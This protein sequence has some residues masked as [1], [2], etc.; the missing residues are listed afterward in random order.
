MRIV[1]VRL[2]ALGDIVHTWPLADA[3]RAASPEAHLTWVVEEPLAPLV[4]ATRR[5]TRS[6]PSPPRAGARNRSPN[7]TRAEIAILKTPIRGAPSGSRHRCP[8]HP[9]IGACHAVDGRRP[10][11]RSG[12]ALAP[13]AH[14]RPR[15]S[16]RLSPGAAT[17]GTWSPPISNSFARSPVNTTDCT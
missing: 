17:T 16:P 9:Q 3:I 14:R 5:S 6:S 11:G 12:S 7:A 15:P 13:G 2:S 4:E 1:L 8:G 10:Q